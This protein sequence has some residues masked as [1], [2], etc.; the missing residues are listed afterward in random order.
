M[1]LAMVVQKLCGIGSD[2][3]FMSV[4]RPAVMSDPSLVKVW[5]TNAGAGTVA[6]MGFNQGTAWKFCTVV[7]PREAL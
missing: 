4:L 6:G 1:P 5:I 7:A 3:I 2:A